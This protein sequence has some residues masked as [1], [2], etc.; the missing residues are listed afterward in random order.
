M[1]IEEKMTG[2]REEEDGTFLIRRTPRF[3]KAI[4]GLRRLGGRS[5]A[6]AE[7]AEELL[8]LLLQ[9]RQTDLTK[10]GRLT[11]N[12]EYR[13]KNCHKFDLGGGYRLVFLTKDEHLIILY[14]GT[15]DECFRWIDRHRD[16]VC[17]P[18]NSSGVRSGEDSKTA[19][20]MDAMTEGVL[21]DQ[22]YSRR[23]EEDLMK[24]IDDMT[25]RRIF[26][27]LINEE[28]RQ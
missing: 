7:K 25:L 11:L 26:G 12:G 24:R 27:S 15:H 10:A 21:R 5:A 28:H 17:E 9:T 8:S 20:V 13:I 22:E 19:D 18:L 14:I 1:H 4:E 23:Y 3:E 2:A 16:L 6:A